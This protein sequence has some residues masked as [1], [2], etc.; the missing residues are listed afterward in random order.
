MPI[1]KQICDLYLSNKSIRDIAS[2][3]RLSQHKVY[4]VLRAQKILRNK[5]EASKNKINIPKNELYRLYIIEGK[6]LTKIARLFGTSHSVVRGKLINFDIPLKRKGENKR[7]YFIEKSVLEDLYTNQRMS[8]KEVAKKLNVRCCS[9]IKYLIEKHK[10][11]LKSLS[12]A[13]TKHFISKDTLRDLYIDQQLSL[14]D[15]SGVLGVSPEALR[16]KLKKY[17]IPISIEAGYEKARIKLYK[18]NKVPTSSQQLLIHSLIGGE[19]NYPLGRNSLDIAFPEDK[20]YVE[21]DGSGHDLAV[22]IGALTAEQ[23]ADKQKRR[24]YYAYRHGWKCIRIICKNDRLPPENELLH[25]IAN[26]INDIKSGKCNFKELDITN[27]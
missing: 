18:Y 5:S 17:N 4:T 27:E 13:N 25:I 12:D 14:L 7:K 24:N 19:L 3:L 23:F 26:C 21:Y 16:Q 2:I 11:K 9:Q 6:N 15:M 1:D 8:L 20:I 22:K 10:I